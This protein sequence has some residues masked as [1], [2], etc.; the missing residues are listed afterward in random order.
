MVGIRSSSVPSVPGQLFRNGV[1]TTELSS[2]HSF[3]PDICTLA[4]PG[5]CG[6]SG[7]GWFFTWQAGAMLWTG[8]HP[9]DVCPS[10]GAGF[11]LNQSQPSK[12]P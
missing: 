4:W 12:V 8:I 5:E 3:A 6:W 10:A 7:S 2:F 9:L 1:V 11:G